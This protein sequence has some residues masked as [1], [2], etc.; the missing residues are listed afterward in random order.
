M[1]LNFTPEQEMLR[2]TVRD[3]CKRRSPP[4][5]VRE[6]EGHEIGY[7][8]ALW[9]EMAD[10]GL[11]GLALPESCGG[12][13][14]GPLELTVLYEELGRALCPSPHFTTAVLA[15]GVIQRAGSA[16]QRDAW[17]GRLAEGK[18]IIACAWLEPDRGCEAAGVQAT[19][20][21]SGD[22][23]TLAGTKLFVPFAHVADRLLVLARSAEGVELFLVDPKAVGVR[24]SRLVTMAG[25]PQFEVALDGVSV[26]ET[27][28]LGVPGQGW[29]TW[30][31]VLQLGL[32]CLGAQAMGMAQMALEMATQYSK[33]RVQFGRPIGSFQAIAHYLADVAT[34]VEGGKTLVY[35]AAWTLAEGLPPGRLAAMAKLYTGESCRHATAV[36]QQV[37]GGMGFIKDV[38]IQLYFRRAKQLQLLWGD[39]RFLEERIAAS[40]LDPAGD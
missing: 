28:R 21:R 34:E 13:G 15:A 9:Q 37:Y 23:W 32:V 27:E 22:T 26:P 24:L 10:L 33:E 7:S 14:Q 36:A 35:Q 8:Q 4:A 16:A 11:L 6:M 20:V 17:L 29:T 40:V 1:D 19:A 12:L 2:S 39:A 3:F 25:D 31:E 38:D 18:A 5:V 30:E